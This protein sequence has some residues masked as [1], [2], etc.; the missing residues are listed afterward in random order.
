MDFVENADVAD[1]SVWPVV[2]VSDDVETV[3]ADDEEVTWG[4]LFGGVAT[5]TFLIVFYFLAL[6]CGSIGSLL[7]F[8]W[9]YNHN[10]LE[11]HIL[12]WLSLLFGLMVIGVSGV[13]YFRSEGNQAVKGFGFILGHIGLF[14]AA[15]SLGVALLN[16]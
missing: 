16:W 4:Y 8:F 14:C 13:C 5:I 2:P 10:D 12:T 7:I 1:S 11:F 6:M 15:A 3:P 9:N